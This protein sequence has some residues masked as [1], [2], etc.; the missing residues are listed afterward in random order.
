VS[1]LIDVADAVAAELNGRVFSQAFTAVRAYADLEE[2]L[3]NP[4]LRVEVVPVEHVPVDLQTRGSAVYACAADVVVRKKLAAAGSSTVKADEV[5]ALV[6][7]VEELHEWLMMRELAYEATWE[8][9]VLISAVVHHHLRQ[10]NQFT[11]IIRVTYSISRCLK[12]SA[13]SS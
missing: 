1:V 5:D 9:T 8:S 10:W 12:H 4:G 6:S 13:E 3:S 2:Q 11:G 7:L